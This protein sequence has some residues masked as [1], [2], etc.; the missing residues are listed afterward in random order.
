MALTLTK[1]GHDLYTQKR[2]Q[3]S[4]GFKIDWKL[5]W[6]TDGQDRF[7]FIAL[8]LSSKSDRTIVI[9]YLTTGKSY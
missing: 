8:Y 5:R 3:T 6:Q 7:D 9:S 1:Y 4:M 2:G